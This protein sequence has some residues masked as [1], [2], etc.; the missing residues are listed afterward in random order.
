LRALTTIGPLLILALLL[1]ACG[2][3]GLPLPP[4]P[5]GPLPPAE[6]AARQL[7]DDVL[8]VFRVPEPRGEKP[9]RQP[10]RAELVRVAYA[11]G[12]EPQTDPSVFRRRGELVAVLEEDPLPSGELRRLSDGL[13]D[14]LQSRG[15]GSTLRYAIRVRDRRGRTSP[16]VV[17]RDL[18]PMAP[19]SAPIGLEAEPT[20]DGVRL[21]WKKPAVEGQLRYNV[22]RSQPGAELPVS[23][24]N[25]HPIGV[26][27]Y[28]DSG[29]ADG[30]SYLYSVRVALAASIPY[31]EGNPSAPL[32]VR[33][34]DRFPPA[35]PQGLVAVQEGA[36]VRLFWDPNRERDLA[37]YRVYRRIDAGE[38]E[39]IGPDPV[40][41]ALYL[42]RE[43]ATGMWL[44]YRVTAVDR[45]EPP[46]ESGLSELV[47]LSMQAEPG[48]G[49]GNER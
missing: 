15:I 26:T 12:Y 8:V 45:A 27:E 28:L 49:A 23:P 41:Q 19:V 34:E 30:E 21:V 16:L 37:G 6:V 18:V 42:D 38:W 13:L 36:A 7:G 39:M 22:Y 47:E 17:A 2:K 46:N 4:Q 32:E 14:K 29:A 20:A 5:K 35:A 44:A 43:V 3:K 31:R 48:S 1:P 24:L 33:A 11:P 9:A 40:E 25:P 10:V